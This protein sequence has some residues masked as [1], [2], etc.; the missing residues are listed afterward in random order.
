MLAGVRAGGAE[1]TAALAP[2]LV[3]SAPVSLQMRWDSASCKSLRGAACTMHTHPDAKAMAIGHCGGPGTRRGLGA[4][5][6]DELGER[7]PS[8]NAGTCTCVRLPVVR[9]ARGW[10]GWERGMGSTTPGLA[11]A[12]ARA[13]RGLSPATPQIPITSAPRLPRHEAAL[14]VDS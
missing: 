6:G 1:C 4:A 14:N 11:C 8:R 13:E 7:G 3:W 12:G 2:G 10:E 9:G 5:I